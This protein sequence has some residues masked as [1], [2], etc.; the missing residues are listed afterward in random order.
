MWSYA[1]VFVNRPTDSLASLDWCCGC[2]ASL[3]GR[4]VTDVERQFLRN[5]KVMFKP[6]RR[7]LAPPGDSAAA[8]C[9]V[10]PQP[11]AGT[12]KVVSSLPGVRQQS[13]LVVS[14][15]QSVSEP[16]TVDMSMVPCTAVSSKQP[17][18]YDSQFRCSLRTRRAPS[19]GWTKPN[20]YCIPGSDSS[21]VF[22]LTH[23]ARDLTHFSH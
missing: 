10:Q 18:Y 7:L 9:S 5:W 14:A 6:E 19:R 15:R 16:A 3:D 17:L 13:M 4:P 2:A 8:A 23:L 22:S 11:S 1:S 20:T 12:A 21:L